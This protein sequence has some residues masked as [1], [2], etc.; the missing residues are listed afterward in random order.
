MQSIAR[1]VGM[2]YERRYDAGKVIT[3]SGQPAGS[4]YILPPEM[5]QVLRTFTPEARDS[6]LLLDACTGIYYFLDS[7]GCRRTLAADDVRA[8][9]MRNMNLPGHTPIYG[10]Y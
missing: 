6:A 3:A 1:E 5:E 4:F 7:D 2:S 10:D 8:T 9:V